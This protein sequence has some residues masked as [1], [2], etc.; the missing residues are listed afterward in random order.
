MGRSG[1][2]GMD[3]RIFPPEPANLREARYHSFCGG[4]RHGL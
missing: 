2:N 1:Y 3:G 4:R